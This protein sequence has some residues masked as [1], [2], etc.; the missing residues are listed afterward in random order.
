MITKEIRFNQIQKAEERTTLN[1]KTECLPLFFIYF[2][3]GV[4]HL[5]SVS[6][7]VYR[8]QKCIYISL[9]NIYQLQM[10]TMRFD[11]NTTVL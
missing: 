2:P 4:I 9:L 7:K 6:L 10:Y 5:N 1:T 3:V 8:I 11:T